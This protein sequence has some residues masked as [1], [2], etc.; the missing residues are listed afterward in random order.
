[1]Q[2]KTYQH[3][4]RWK[5]VLLVEMITGEIKEKGGKSNHYRPERDVE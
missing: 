1:M 4:G 2:L 5:N 3:K